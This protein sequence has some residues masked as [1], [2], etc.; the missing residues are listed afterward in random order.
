MNFYIN[1]PDERF[2][3]TSTANVKPR[4]VITDARMYF[5]VCLLKEP[6]FQRIQTKLNSG[7]DLQINFLNKFIKVSFT[8]RRTDKPTNRQTDGQTHPL[9]ESWL[10]TKKKQINCQP[11]FFYLYR[12]LPLPRESW[13]PTSMS[14]QKMTSTFF[15]SSCTKT[16]RMWA[17]LIQTTCALKCTILKELSCPVQCKQGFLQ[18]PMDTQV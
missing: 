2:F 11:Y 4:F 6:V 8:D 18:F 17:R 5:N 13:N 14:P 10:Q 1:F 15:M 16:L 12:H 9:I 3:M 7:S